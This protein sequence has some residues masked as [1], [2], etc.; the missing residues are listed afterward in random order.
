MQKLS[1]QTVLN[2][3]EQ[4]SY[5]DSEKVKEIMLRT[6]IN[7]V[8]LISYRSSNNMS[9]HIYAEDKYAAIEKFIESTD[10]YVDKD[11]NII[12]LLCNRCRICGSENINKCH[13]KSHTYTEFI[14]FYGTHVFNKKYKCKQ[15]DLDSLQTYSLL[16]RLDIDDCAREKDLGITFRFTK[17]NE[18]FEMKAEDLNKAIMISIQKKLINVNIFDFHRVV[19][20]KSKCKYNNWNFELC[21]ECSR[22]ICFFCNRPTIDKEHF[23]NCERD[24]KNISDELLIK[25]V[26][27]AYKIEENVIVENE[28]KINKFKEDVRR[29]RNMKNKNFLM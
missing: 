22:G 8:Y 18:Y 16:E 21:E 20:C 5:E 24:F 10:F 29:N 13:L 9:Y 12:D 23:Y 14:R 7:N 17:G 19:V 28:E 27:L 25:Y 4:M 2:L 15:I 6:K 11:E 1:I 26:K 3:I